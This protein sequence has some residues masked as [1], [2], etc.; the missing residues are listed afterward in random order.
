MEIAER[1]GSIFSILVTGALNKCILL[2][3]VSCFKGLRRLDGGIAPKLAKI[4]YET[5]QQRNMFGR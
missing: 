4:A 2:L 3:N 5:I 1:V